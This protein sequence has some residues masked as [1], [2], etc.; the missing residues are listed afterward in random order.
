MD[1]SKLTSLP[2]S[3]VDICLQAVDGLFKPDL[4]IIS[5][6]SSVPWHFD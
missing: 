6:F 5:F 1:E 3:P 2:T 4:E